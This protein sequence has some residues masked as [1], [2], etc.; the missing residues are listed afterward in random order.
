MSLGHTNAIS[1]VK[2]K[3]RLQNSEYWILKKITNFRFLVC[4]PA[5]L[6]ACLTTFEKLEA[7]WCIARPPFYG[8]ISSSVVACAFWGSENNPP[9]P[10][11][12]NSSCR[13]LL[14]ARKPCRGINFSY[15]HSLYMHIS[16]YRCHR[17]NYYTE[18]LTRGDHARCH[19]K[20]G[21]EMNSL[22][23]NN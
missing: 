5:C 1:S 4:L 20:W 10:F 7:K 21:R 14:H 16:Q 18:A 6:P 9:L 11:I 13:H 17:D 15:Q 3:N 19:W 2:N 8:T 23:Y 12:S 22:V